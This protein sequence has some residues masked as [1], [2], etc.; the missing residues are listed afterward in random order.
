MSIL[1]LGFQHLSVRMSIS[2]YHLPKG[3]G[4]LRSAVVAQ[5]HL[6]GM[7][8][9]SMVS[10]HHFAFLPPSGETGGQIPVLRCTQ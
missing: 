10:R 3:Q 6:Q 9:L 2:G 1:P 7:E 8:G 4:T 5:T